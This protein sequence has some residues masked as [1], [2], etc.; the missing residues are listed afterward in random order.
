MTEPKKNILLCVS[1]GIAAYKAIDLASQ[2]IKHGMK[3]R[4]ILSK[5]AREFVTELSFRAITNEVVHNDLFDCEDPIPHI[6]NAS[7][8][9]LIVIAPATANVIAKIACGIADDLLS[10][11]LLAARCPVLIV[12]A[13]NVF[14]YENKA[15][16]VNLAVLKSRGIFI[17]EPASGML[18]CGY[19]GKGKYPPNEEVIFAIETYLQH[20]RDLEGIKVMVTAGATVE[21]IDPMRYISNRS[22]GKMGFAIARA[23]SLRGAEV[24]LVFGRCDEPPP[25][26]LMGSRSGSGM[27]ESE[28]VKAE[29]V[30]AM[31][32]EVMKRAS[33][34][35]WI[36]KCAAVSDYK[37][38]H[39]Q[40]HKIKKD[41][42]LV[43][44]T[45]KTIDILA[46]LGKNKT[47]GQK[48]IGFAAET[49]D[50]ENNAAKKLRAKNLDLVVANDLKVSGQENTAIVVLGYESPAEGESSLKISKTRFEGSKFKAAHYL[51][52][53]IKTL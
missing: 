37:P 6:N 3:V 35:D 41:M 17:L 31:Y 5:N 15:C 20:G 49:E 13:M 45:I 50:I 27:T 34:M 48:L 52:D 29:T 51:L 43:I 40:E 16:Q 32:A 25:Y 12:P 1:G 23:A 42:E 26:Y 39:V 36:I 10:A 44:E 4:T 9:E 14:M 11:T 22:S 38:V 19:E 18:A 2:L 46:E 33:G 47:P 21:A 24:H 53:T 28:A 7:W 8:A 30:D